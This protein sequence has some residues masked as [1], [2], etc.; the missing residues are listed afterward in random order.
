MNNIIIQKGVQ[1]VDLIELN[2][3][4]ETEYA[5]IKQYC[6]V[7]KLMLES[8]YNKIKIF[9]NTLEKTYVVFGHKEGNYTPA[10]SMEIEKLDLIGK[11]R[12]EV[13]LEINDNKERK[14]W[15]QL[16]LYCNLGEIE[17]FGEKLYSLISVD[18]ANAIELI[19]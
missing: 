11:I 1:E 3:F 6:Y 14:H 10:F 18:S 4:V 17:R 9:I 13:D 5:K 7:D 2:I 8:V 19:E 12:I 15:C 16:Y